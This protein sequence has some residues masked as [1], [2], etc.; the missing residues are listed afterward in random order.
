MTTHPTGTREEWLEA[1]LD[2]LNAEKEYSRQGDEL[3]RQRQE[4]PWVRI[5]KEYRFDTGDGSASLKD[6]FG[7][8]SQLLVYHFMFGP[9]YKAGCPSCS[10]IADGFN[11]ITTHLANHDVMLWAVS[12][13]PLAKLQAY[14]HRMGWSFPWASSFGGDFN[15][16]FSASF[17]EEQ[18]REGAFYNFRRDDPEM[19]AGRGALENPVSNGNAAMAGTDLSTYLRERE[20][21]SAFALEDGA[22]YHTYS[23]YA[24]GVDAIWSMY[25]WLDRAPKG[26]NATGPWLRRHDEYS[27]G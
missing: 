27:H 20:G 17:T 11:G 13:A 23:A 15:F 10:A 8:R 2:L 21:L 4:L 3:A 12:R 6:F 5:D 7:G 19:E 14:K 26:R 22:I 24:R 9:D 16:D 25:Q 1:R 18:Q